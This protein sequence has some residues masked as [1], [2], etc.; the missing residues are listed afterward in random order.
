MSQVI[1][2]GEGMMY[3]NAHFIFLN[4]FYSFI[5]FLSCFCFHLRVNNSGKTL[6]YL[7]PLVTHVLDQPL[8]QPKI[9]GPIAIILTVRIFEPFV[10]S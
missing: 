2:E 9:D 1:Q 8:I 7:L 6:A 3:F 10:P 5:P 4:C